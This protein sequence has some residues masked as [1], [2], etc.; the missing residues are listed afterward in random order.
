MRVPNCVPS[1]L[2]FTFRLLLSVPQPWSAP[3]VE[4]PVDFWEEAL[5]W[6]Q[7]WAAGRS[8]SPL[9]VAPNPTPSPQPRPAGEASGSNYRNGDQRYPLHGRRE[10]I[11]RNVLLP[12]IGQIGCKISA[13]VNELE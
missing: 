6:E 10:T 13:V 9:G 4:V 12:F 3:A 11:E 2:V 1:S 8:A 7:A 5:A